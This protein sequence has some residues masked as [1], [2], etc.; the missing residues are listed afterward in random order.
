MSE[1]PDSP[2]SLRKATPGITDSIC[3]PSESRVAALEMRV[4]S[5]HS[6]YPLFLEKN[7]RDKRHKRH[8][9]VNPES[10][11]ISCDR[12]RTDAEKIPGG[13]DFFPGMH[14]RYQNCN[15]LPSIA[16]KIF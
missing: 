6:P 9:M 15:N 3:K 11:C 5:I 10:P 12:Q 2:S 14:I 4:F 13:T 1:I 16:D 7:K 8:G